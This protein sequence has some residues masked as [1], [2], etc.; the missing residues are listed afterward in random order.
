[1]D[2]RFKFRIYFAPENKMLYFDSPC[3]NEGIINKT[4]KVDEK[5][6]G[7]LFACSEY[8][9]KNIDKID[10]KDLSPLMQCTGQKDRNGNLIYE[11]DIAKD[12]DVYESYLVVWDIDTAS[13]RLKQELWLNE[14]DNDIEIIG[15]IYENHELLESLED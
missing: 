13:F 5:H 8:N 15:N 7:L 11:G 9:F 6:Q 12:E 3:L 1:M 2:D 10:K 4:K 14:F